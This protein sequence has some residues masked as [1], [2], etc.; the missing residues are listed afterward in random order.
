MEDRVN[1]VL[2]IDDNE[3]IRRLA[4][5]LLTKRNYAVETAKNGQEGIEIAKR[6]KP[7]VILLDVMMPG[8]DGYEVCKRIK[9]DAEIADI[10]VIIVTSKTETFD[11]IHG[12]E[13]G[14][15]DYVMKPFD[16]GELLARIATQVKLKNLYDELQE[17]NRILEEMTRK[18][19]LTDL[20]NRRYF[21]ERI[22]E[23]FS[24]ARRY[25]FPMSFI[26]FDIDHFKEINDSYGHQ[27]GDDVLRNLARI[28]VNH[29]RDVDVPARYGG[30]EFSLIL[31]HTTLKNAVIFAERL[32]EE[33]AKHPFLFH[34]KR[35]PVTISLGVAGIPDNNPSSCNELIRFADE[36]LY[37]AKQAGRNRTV[38]YMRTTE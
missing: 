38:M 15:A 19:G 9:E 7:Q 14:A 30:E 37:R 2:V 33:V 29:I 5:T 8:M 16:Q 28:L 21:Q 35:I 27:A 23:E 4:K 12:L 3:V 22:A 36:A 18:D 34:E 6:I 11:R 10:P 17:K 32:R 25:D 13:I 26:M 31:P 1:T 24:R 20:F